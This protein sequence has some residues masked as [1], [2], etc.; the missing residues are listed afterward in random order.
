MFKDMGEEFVLK[1]AGKNIISKSGIHTEQEVADFM[2]A[3]QA[4]REPFGNF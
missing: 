4:V 1:E 2:C 3:E